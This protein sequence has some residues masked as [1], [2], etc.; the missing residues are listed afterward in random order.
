[1]AVCFWYFVK[2][3][4]SSVQLYSNVYWTSH[5]LQCPR[6]TW[7]CFFGHPVDVG[8]IVINKILLHGA[9]FL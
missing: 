8:L 3:D 5:I 4:L 1:M 6:N 2:S 9:N 7:P